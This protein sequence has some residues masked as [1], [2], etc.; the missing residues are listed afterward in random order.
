MTRPRPGSRPVP[1]VTAVGHVH[2]ARPPLFVGDRVGSVTR[3][4]GRASTVDHPG[5]R[6][7]RPPGTAHTPRDHRTGF[8][9]GFTAFSAL[10]L[11]NRPPGRTRMHPQCHSHQPASLR[12]AG[13]TARGHGRGRVGGQGGGPPTCAG[14]PPMSVGGWRP[15][16]RL[17]PV[18]RAPG[19]EGAGRR[20]VACLPNAPT[21]Q[22]PAAAAVART[23]RSL[24]P[25]GGLRPPGGGPDH[26]H[27]PGPRGHPR[28]CGRALH[29]SDGA[30][31]YPGTVRLRYSPTTGSAAL[32]RQ[33]VW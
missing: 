8:C 2:G 9:R 27:Q 20:Q 10:R 4:T 26:S 21:S 22:P 17:A 28:S 15:G 6:R 19:T 32:T 25:G 13:H 1:A 11:R 12:H 18:S 24:H 33:P 14:G 3:V 16:H 23:S 29:P 7:T 5:H 30:R 31:P